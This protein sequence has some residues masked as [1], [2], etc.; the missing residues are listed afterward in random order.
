ML[1]Y[2]V[3]Q[4]CIVV[5]QWFGG[6]EVSYGGVVVGTAHHGG[7]KFRWGFPILVHRR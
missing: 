3:V 1:R 2:P 5:L 4:R 7:Q 6:V